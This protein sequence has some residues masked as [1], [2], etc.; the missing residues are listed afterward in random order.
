MALGHGVVA[1][2]SQRGLKSITVFI[3][4]GKADFTIHSGS[5][6]FQQ[7]NSLAIFHMVY[8]I[9]QRSVGG[10]IDLGRCLSGSAEG[11]GAE[12]MGIG[13]GDLSVAVCGSGILIPHVLDVDL[14]VLKAIRQC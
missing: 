1:A 3:C 12:P 5:A 4:N 9:L 2:G 8:R 13:E 11:K 6:V 10:A 14:L 7:N